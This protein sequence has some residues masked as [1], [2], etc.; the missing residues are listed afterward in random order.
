MLGTF[1]N[2]IGRLKF[3]LSFKLKGNNLYFYKKKF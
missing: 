2:E 1:Y 3:K